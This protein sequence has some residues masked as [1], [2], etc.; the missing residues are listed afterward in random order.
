MSSMSPIE[1]IGTA[2][3]GH[4]DGVIQRGW[5]VTPP[6]EGS[7]LFPL[8]VHPTRTGDIT[9]NEKKV[10]IAEMKTAAVDRKMGRS[11]G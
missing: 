10:V 4:K 3:G 9:G 7:R 1:T 2:P 11:S 8:A 5:N 6:P